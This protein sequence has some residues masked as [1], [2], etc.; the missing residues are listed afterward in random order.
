MAL[1]KSKAIFTFV[2]SVL[3]PNQ[4][5]LLAREYFFLARGCCSHG[6]LAGLAHYVAGANE[7]MSPVFLT[8][9]TRLPPTPPQTRF[10]IGHCWMG[11]CW[12][13]PAFFVLDHHPFSSAAIISATLFFGSPAVL[14]FV[15]RISSSLPFLLCVWMCSPDKVTRPLVCRYGCFAIRLSIKCPEKYFILI[16]HRTS[17]A[18]TSGISCARVCQSFFSEFFSEFSL[19]TTICLFFEYTHG[20]Q[21]VGLCV[22][23]YS[24]SLFF[25]FALCMY[26]CGTNFGRMQSW[27]FLWFSF[28]SHLW[29]EDCKSK[30]GVGLSRL[31]VWPSSSPCLLSLFLC[32]QVLH[33]LFNLVRNF[34]NSLGILSLFFASLLGVNLTRPVFRHLVPLSSLPSLPFSLSS[35]PTLPLSVPSACHPYYLGWHFWKQFFLIAAIYSSIAL[36]FSRGSF[37]FFFSIRLVSFHGFCSIEDQ[38][39]DILFHLFLIWSKLDQFFVTFVWLFSSLGWWSFFFF[40]RQDI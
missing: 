14:Y 26:V 34:V 31:V 40:L 20:N 24:L 9:A 3:Q 38:S 32:S 16:L 19:I 17:L 35:T 13:S 36:F 6:W 22:C 27:L 33:L 10:W 15:V 12:A 8:T 5:R 7:A 30:T 37:V 11:H 25:F 18:T 29:C 21:V 23:V 39:G 4:N 1:P 28:C 2:Q